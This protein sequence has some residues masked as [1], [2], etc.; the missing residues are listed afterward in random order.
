[1]RRLI[2]VMIL[3]IA[4]IGTSIVQDATTGSLASSAG[5]PV[6]RATPVPTLSAVDLAV[7]RR[8]S[9]VVDP[10]LL[11]SYPQGYENEVV[12]VQGYALAVKQ[13]EQITLVDFAA[14]TPRGTTV[15]LVIGILPPERDFLSDEC[16]TFYGGVIG[17]VDADYHLLDG[18]E[19]TPFIAAYQHLP[20]L[21]EEP[22]RCR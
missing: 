10:R 15:P 1:M 20:G 4:A 13:K 12:K 7:L 17:T 9:K 18:W 22:W 14:L 6:A 8:Q 16:Y 2:V 5:T 11:A 21:F 19:G 3:T